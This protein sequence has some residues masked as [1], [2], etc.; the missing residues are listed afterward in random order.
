MIFIILQFETI[1]YLIHKDQIEIA[2]GEIALF[3]FSSYKKRSGKSTT[4]P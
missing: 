2:S 1:N 4:W 3:K